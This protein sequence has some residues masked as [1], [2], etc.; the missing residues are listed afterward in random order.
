MKEYKTYIPVALIILMFLSLIIFHKDIATYISQ[1]KIEQLSANT[2]KVSAT[3][4][5]KNTTIIITG[6]LTITRSLN[7]LHRLSLLPP[8]GRSHGEN[9]NRI[10]REGVN[11]VFINLME[12][13]SK[14]FFEYYGVANSHPSTTWTRR[15]RVLPPHRLLFGW[16]TINTFH[17]EK[18]NEER[19]LK[20]QWK[21][22]TLKIT[23]VLKFRTLVKWSRWLDFSTSTSSFIINKLTLVSLSILIHFLMN[24]FNFSIP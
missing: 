5:P 15:E 1:S 16:R 3:R 8:N 21:Q 19:L 7:W 18:V 4:L 11:I 6:K 17:D 2:K 20:F 24:K 23:R 13:E 9:K 22:G 14:R 12:P 10:Q